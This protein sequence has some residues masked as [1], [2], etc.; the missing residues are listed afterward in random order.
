MKIK[1]LV[2]TGLYG[3]ID[4]DITF[5]DDLTLLVGING[6]GKTSI[7]N[8]INWVLKPS[9][10]DL[11]VTEFKS[12]ELFFSYK[13]V[14][15]HILCKYVKLRFIYHIKSEN[16]DYFPLSV[17]ISYSP[18]SIKNDDLLKNELIRHYSLLKPNGV[19]EERTWNLISKFPH[20]IVLGLDRN[21]G[22][23]DDDAFQIDS[24]IRLGKKNSTYNI[25][26]VDRV[27]Q[28]VNRE[29]RIRKNKVQILTNALKNQL[30]LSTFDDS[31]S[32]ESFRKG[33]QFKIT[34]NKIIA[35]EQKVNNFFDRFVEVDSVSG[36]QFSIKN[37]FEQL[38]LITIK[39]ESNLNDAQIELLYG[40]NCYQFSK[41]V[42]LLNQFK[43][44]E[45]KSEKA[46]EQIT[47]Y[48]ETLNSFFQDSSKEIVFLDDTGEI[49]F[50]TLDKNKNIVSK[51][52]D[53]KFLSS[54]ERQILILF[55]YL[56]FNAHE[57]KIFII[58]EPE[59]S[60]HIKWQEDFINKLND[61]NSTKTQIILA[62]HSPNIA[63]KNKLKSVVLMPYNV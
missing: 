35:A 52:N 45:F 59:L 22:F 37:Y 6:A 26:P 2:V 63:Y 25:S 3:H 44:F 32:I 14:N 36:Q 40:L 50:N 28:M 46:L 30:M 29:Y 62:T 34:I 16:E 42:D 9:L 57:G 5:N 31:I 56:A 17:K 47:I 38:K 20:P 10:S 4:K 39:Y 15:Y 24:T 23:N 51:Y 48:L 43:V 7:L 60:L 41:V 54:G 18:S 12:I 21:I 19:K 55:S 13:L 49:C 8:I 1:R 53:I 58:D 33:L 27:K 11:C 61:L